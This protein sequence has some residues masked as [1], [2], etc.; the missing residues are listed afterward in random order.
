MTFPAPQSPPRWWLALP[1]QPRPY[2]LFLRAPLWRWWRPLLAAVV[3]VVA[4]VVITAI[5]TVPGL[6]LDDGATAVSPGEPIR[7]GPWFFLANNVILGL[8]I[9]LVMLVQW[10]VMGQRPGWISSIAGRVRWRW[11]FQSLAVAGSV[12]V[13]MFAVE[14]AVSP[15]ED[16]RWREYTWL[17]IIGILITTPLQ[18]AGEE[19]LLRGLLTRLVGSYFKKPLFGWVVAT[20]VSSVLFMRLHMAQ[21]AWLNTYYLVFGVIASWVVWRTGGLEAAVAIHVANNMTAEALL[22]WSEISGLMDR[23][24]GMGDATIL[25]HITALVVITVALTRLARR[26]GLTSEPVPGRVT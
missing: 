19:Y 18:S 21:D 1:T 25:I 20:T 23:S 4:W 26:R 12:M 6:I 14:L 11:L 7:I 5:I 17:L 13:V 9:P 16:L 8:S 10:A 22:P 24:E 3:T 2:H 15:P